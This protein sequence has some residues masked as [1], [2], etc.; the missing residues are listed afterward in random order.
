MPPDLAEINIFCLSLVTIG[1]YSTHFCLRENNIPLAEGL[2][3]ETPQ[4]RRLCHSYLN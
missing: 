2:E 1:D 4:G 3:K